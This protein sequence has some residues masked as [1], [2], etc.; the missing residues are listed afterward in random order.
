MSIT[1]IDAI[2]S[3]LK[4]PANTLGVDAGSYAVKIISLSSGGTSGKYKINAW[5][6]LPL[7]LE[8][9]LEQ[10]QA[11]LRMVYNA[12]LQTFLSQNRSVTRDTTTGVDGPAIIVRTISIPKLTY[13]EL[14]KTIQFEAEP[15]LPVNINECEIGFHIIGPTKDDPKKMDVLIA[16]VKK[17]AIENKVSLLNDAGLRTVVVDANAFALANV[18]YEMIS[19]SSKE[20]RKGDSSPK[21]ETVIIMNIGASVTNMILIADGV[22]KL[23]RDLAYGGNEFTKSVQRQMTV[24]FKGAEKLKT[25]YGILLSGE[26]KE[27][28]LADDKREALSVSIALNTSAKML[29]GDIHRFIE[30]YLGQNPDAVFSR[31]LISGGTAL[32]PNLI[33]YI[34]RETNIPTEVFNPIQ[35]LCSSEDAALIP[36]QYQPSLATAFGL[37]LRKEKDHLS[38]K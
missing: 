9:S 19:A 25:T 21:P 11:E 18:Y 2:K 17:E 28:T 3:L 32:L 34:S 15:F 8:T 6:Y 4:G 30:F 13:Q 5:G 16:A 36:Q 12:R 24:D 10:S 35:V 37:A 23:V 14:A 33:S 27:K 7:E 26:D 38:K 22:V 1:A 20:K 29:V 31:I